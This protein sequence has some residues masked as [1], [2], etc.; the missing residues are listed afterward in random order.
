MDAV[1]ERTER[2]KN[3]EK[4]LALKDLVILGQCYIM[5]H[6]HSVFQEIK[7]A[8]HLNEQFYLLFYL[9]VHHVTLMR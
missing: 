2:F 8:S 9:N 4:D 1:W 7:T 5:R 6:A 3:T